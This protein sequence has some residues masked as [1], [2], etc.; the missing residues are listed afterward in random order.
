MNKKSVL[1]PEG[2]FR[3]KLTGA[4]AALFAAVALAGA[5]SILSVF[6]PGGFS[7]FRETA[8]PEGIKTALVVL[9][10]LLTEA[11]V[12]EQV[13]LTFAILLGAS[14]LFG[15]V[16]SAALSAGIFQMQRGKAAHGAQLISRSAKILFYGT[17]AV[18]LGAA[19]LFV[20]RF[21]TYCMMYLSAGSKGLVFMLTGVATELVLGVLAAFAVLKL[22]RFFDSA[23]DCALSIS[24]ALTTGVLT[25]PTIS[26]T[27]AVGCLVLG[28][29]SVLIALSCANIMTTAMFLCGGAADIVM[30]FYLRS[31][32]R[33]SEYLLYKGTPA[34]VQE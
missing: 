19:V 9:H 25:A 13:T 2:T 15:T 12:D 20:I 34:T 18:G 30:F 26:M 28:I 7:L 31:F 11:P 14:V 24:R 4:A 6:L 22:R 33:S 5:L 1:I 10:G 27:P 32:K 16:F 21:V 3:S 17:T 23:G 8:A 29:V